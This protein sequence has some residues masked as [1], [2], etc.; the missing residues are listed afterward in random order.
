MP[1][2]Y[3]LCI[4]AP[5]AAALWSS[6]ELSMEYAWQTSRK[7]ALWPAPRQ[8]STHIPRIKAMVSPSTSHWYWD[9]VTHESASGRSAW[10]L[11]SAVPSNTTLYSKL[12]V[13]LLL[14]LLVLL[15]LVLVLHTTSRLRLRY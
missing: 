15:L 7:Y 8:K 2:K 6:A 9:Q 14:L 13:L 1:L 12:L 10:R 4:C 3:V 5:P 11:V